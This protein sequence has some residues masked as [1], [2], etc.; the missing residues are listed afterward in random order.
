MKAGGSGN[1]T[2]IYPHLLPMLPNFIDSIESD[3]L[4]EYLKLFITNIEFGL[5]EKII[6]S[7]Q[8]RSDITAISKALFECIRY[9]LSRIDSLTNW[10]DEII[11]KDFGNHLI[12]SHV[13]NLYKWSVETPILPQCGKV[14]YLNMASLIN[15]LHE[16]VD[17][18][19]VFES[20][21][22]LF[23]SDVMQYAETSF[24]NADNLDHEIESHSNWLQTFHGN[25]CGL[26]K[27]KRK[28]GSRVKFCDPNETE[29]QVDEVDAGV[30]NN[31]VFMYIERV[32]IILCKAYIK[33]ATEYQNPLFITHVERI[34][35]K[36]E[37]SS[38]LKK[39]YGDDLMKLYEKF[40]V[41]LM[42]S[43]MRSELVVDLIMLLYKHMSDCD[44]KTVLNKLIKVKFQG[45]TSN[46]KCNLVIVLYAFSLQ[47]K[48]FNTGH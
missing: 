30:E 16:N 22:E 35:S 14:L 13:N 34:F 39:M 41:W 3:K 12:S 6:S 18:F 25:L 40:S 48:M 23:W 20:F 27:S 38:F 47:L 24:K 45:R 46:R 7:G 15:Y 31:S 19:K 44:K 5:R 36:F 43:N 9:V 21:L 1:A 42:L 32:A 28:S 8:A 11:K 33:G 4:L 37:S 10:N 29:P 2:V 17:K 26:G